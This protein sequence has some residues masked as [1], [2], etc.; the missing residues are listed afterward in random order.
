MTTTEPQL[1]QPTNLVLS[2]HPNRSEGDVVSLQFDDAQYGRYVL[3]FTP[4]ATAYLAR[5]F[6]AA[7]HSPRVQAEA[8]Q[9]KARQ[10]DSG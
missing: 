6:N 1:L 3:A 5:L 10:R 4:E 9:I 7:A 8:D 2:Y